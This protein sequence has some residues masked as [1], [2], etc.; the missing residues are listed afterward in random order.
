MNRLASPWS[1][2]YTGHPTARID[3]RLTL[4][5]ALPASLLLVSACSEVADAPPLAPI[6]PVSTQA[7]AVDDLVAIHAPEVFVRNAGAPRAETRALSTAGFEGPFR[8]HVRSGDAA[9]DGRVSSARVTVDGREVL[10]PSAFNQQRAEW[11]VELELGGVAALEVK[12]AGAPGS[13]LEVTL[14]GRRSAIVFCPTGANGAVADLQTAVNMAPENGTVLVCDGEHPADG[15]VVNKSLEIRSQNPGGAWLLDQDPDFLPNTARPAIWA[16]G[17]SV[18]VVDLGFRVRGRG[19]AGRG[20]LQELTL[21]SARFSS[22]Q[23]FA[24]A[25]MLESTLSASAEVRVVRSA[26]E[27]VALGVLSNAGTLTVTESQF[28][29]VRSAISF[30]GSSAGSAQANVIRNC[31]AGDCVVVRSPVSGIT[32]AGNE[33]I[34]DDLS[35]PGGFG[36]A[37]RRF[38]PVP[39]ASVL[40]ENNTITG[41]QRAGSPTSTASWT[42]QSAVIVQDVAGVVNEIRGNT[43]SGAWNAVRITGGV[44]VNDNFIGN[45][46]YAFWESGAVAAIPGQVRFARNDATGLLRSFRAASSVANYRCNWWGSAAG[47]QA[48]E[49]SIASTAYTPSASGAIAGRPDVICSE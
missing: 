46:V 21:E 25:V 19:L 1:R 42:I 49:G 14:Y 28:D 36:I 27:M 22:R 20:A 23:E 44:N 29:H 6:A 12:L 41:T 15:V 5:I 31:G 48:I 4:R 47:P 33:L 39:G 37:I 40:V 26:F 8:L 11:T 34:A 45:G 2:C 30:S 3:M 7:L 35:L 32:V 13:R 18:R 10:G 43:I 38:G 16:E 24:R 17:G 9:G